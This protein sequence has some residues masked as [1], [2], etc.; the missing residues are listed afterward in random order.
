MVLIGRLCRIRPVANGDLAGRRESTEQ[1]QPPGLETA[2]PSDRLD[3]MPP[4]PGI[5]HA[6]PAHRPE[7]RG[8]GEEQLCSR[9]LMFRS[10]RS[11]LIAPAHRGCARWL[12]RDGGCRQCRWWRFDLLVRRHRRRLQR[13]QCQMCQ[14]VHTQSRL[15]GLA[16]H[17]E[18]PG[19]SQPAAST[20]A[21]VGRPA[22]LGR[23]P[24]LAP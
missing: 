15:T 5:R 12:Y 10:D 14:R 22:T 1:D 7:S 11:Q 21:A 16:V 19:S 8:M 17:Q 9:P 24:L 2:D 18:A 20:S 23:G 13:R 4:S 3:H 6:P